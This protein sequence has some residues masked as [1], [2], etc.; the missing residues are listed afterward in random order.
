MVPAFGGRRSSKTDRR[1]SFFGK[2]RGGA[3]RAPCTHRHRV[4]T[5][6]HF[7]R[8]IGDWMSYYNHRRLHRALGMKTPAATY[9]LT[10]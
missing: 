3:G 6:Q 5:L 4:E 7:S 1:R 8:V 2:T 9:A 10:G